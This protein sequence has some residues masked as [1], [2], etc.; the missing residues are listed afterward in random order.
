MNQADQSS[1]GDELMDW[2]IGDCCRQARVW[3]E[4]GLAPIIGVNVSPRQ[5]LAP[6][7]ATRFA[8]RVDADGLAAVNFALEL[9]ESAWTVDAADSLEVIEDLRSAGFALALDDFGAGYSS[10][11]RLLDLGFDVIK[12]DGRL[13]IDVPADPVAVK[14]LLAVFELASACSTDIVAEGVETPAQLQFLIAN[15]ISHAQG[16]AL[17]SP[18]TARELTP[19]LHQQFVPGP[20]PRRGTRHDTGRV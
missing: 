8:A 13:L 15:G 1:A 3:L 20:P 11:S 12:V 7:F 17:G 4:A 19:L 18:M 2:V 6:G 14:L 10:L 16:F 9:T 5:L